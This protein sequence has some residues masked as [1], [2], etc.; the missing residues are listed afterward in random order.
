MTVGLR[1]DGERVRP[2]WVGSGLVRA[3]PAASRVSA[4]LGRLRLRRCRAR[5]AAAGSGRLG[6]AEGT[7]D[8]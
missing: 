1:D 2:A 6:P 4:G 7:R 8:D 3:L 5:R